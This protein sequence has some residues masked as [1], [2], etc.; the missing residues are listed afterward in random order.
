MAILMMKL[1][2][3][4]GVHQW[5]SSRVE[6][7]NGQ[8]AVII[9][10]TI[11]P[12]D[13]SDQLYRWTARYKWQKSKISVRSIHGC[14]YGEWHVLIPDCYRWHVASQVIL[15]LNVRDIWQ[16][17][18]CF[19]TLLT[20]LPQPLPPSLLFQIWKLEENNLV[21][22]HQCPSFA[23]IFFGGSVD[24]TKGSTVLTVHIRSL[25]ITF[26]K[27]HK[28]KPTSIY[29]PSVME[30]VAEVDRIIMCYYVL[31]LTCSWHDMYM[32]CSQA[33]FQILENSR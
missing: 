24:T 4:S 27:Y 16:S 13:T 22:F 7:N 2:Q 14:N 5:W 10:P 20:L 29:L 32:T 26:C 25:W 23:V 15:L 31:K 18:T 3:A 6:W 33:N 8:P 12:H 19:F 9:T 17:D 21:L 28:N 30:I 11:A 1:Y